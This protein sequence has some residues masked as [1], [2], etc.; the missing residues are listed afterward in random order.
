MQKAGLGHIIWVSSSS[1]RGGSGLLLGPYFTAKTARHSL[2]LSLSTE[3][4]CWGI[5]TTIV[6]PGIFTSGTSHFA[7]SGKPG[8]LK[9]ATEYT[10]REGPLKGVETVMMDDIDR[11]F[12]KDTSPE[13]VSNAILKAVEAP[14]GSKPFRVSVHPFQDGSDDIIALAG[15]KYEEF[16]ERCENL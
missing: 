11:Q 9:I 6:V 12:P 8:F 16:L 3:I 15:D 7:I 14:K 10:G 1:A 5:E 2:A 4:A 13:L